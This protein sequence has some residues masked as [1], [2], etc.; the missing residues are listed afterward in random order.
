MFFFGFCFILLLILNVDLQRSCGLLLVVCL[1]EGSNPS[2]STNILGLGCHK[3]KLGKVQT[4]PCSGGV[5][6][7]DSIIEARDF[8]NKTNKR[9][10]Y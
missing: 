8:V 5:F 4:F 7:F 10:R 2:T 3:G 9:K 6:G 1:D